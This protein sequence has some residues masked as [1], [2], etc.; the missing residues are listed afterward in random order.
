MIKNIFVII[1]ALLS[2]IGM[3]LTLDK[4]LDFLKSLN[5]ND[6]STVLIFIAFVF[7]IYKAFK[8]KDKRLNIIATIL[9]LIFALFE[10]V[11]NTIVNNGNLEGIFYDNFS[12]T[13]NIFKIIYY[14]TI[15]YSIIKIL[16][17]FFQKQENKN[18]KE[19]KIFTNNKKS[20]LVVLLILMICWLPYFLKYFPGMI[21]F[22][23][24]EQIK[25]AVGEKPLWDGNPISTTLFI[26]AIINIT[27]PIF[28]SLTISVGICT[29]LK[30]IFMA[31]ILSYSI[32]YLA[33]KGVNYKIRL[34]VLAFFAIN[35]MIGLYSVSLEK[36][37]LFAIILAFDFILLF[38][39][40]TNTDDFIKSKLKIIIAFIFVLLTA[41]VRHNGIYIYILVIPFLYIALRKKYIKLSI[42]VASSIISI[43]LI[44][45][46][47][48][49]G[50]NVIKSSSTEMFS[51]P[52]QAIARLAKY[53]DINLTEKEKNEIDLY[54]KYD[55]LAEAYNPTLADPE[56][57]NFRAEYIEKHKMQF[58]VLNIKLFV[59]YPSYYIEAILCNTS[60]YWFPESQ[61]AAFDKGVISNEL[62]IK[63]KTIAKNNIT[64]TLEQAT[65]NRQIPVIGMLFSTGFTLWVLMVII[66][67]IIYEKKYKLLV[68]FLPSIFNY[69]IILLGP[70][71][72]EF[73]YIIPMY[74]PLSIMYC[75]TINEIKK[76]KDSDKNE[77]SSINTMLQ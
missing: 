25:E 73:R 4:N 76:E 26:K 61:K 63:T 59:H 38:E 10:V 32:Y 56:K 37:S 35:P 15:V 53:N 22:D 60:G 12:I 13:K 68:A 9:G 43:Y 16:Y 66:F 77:N 39:F 11:G 71:N 3:N 52:L 70:S 64:D 47:L 24:L 33:K 8:Y 36:D 46:I 42:F 75:I 55:K 57:G 62:G 19:Y 44:N 34:L 58:I 1:L 40:V 31:L 41:L 51:A 27:M 54:V 14:T 50:F 74:L 28:N 5:G 20:I 21:G 2:T 29:F 72:T 18:I 6:I 69:I 48:I 49:Y 45:T 23:A 30:M 67:Y 17:E 65:E 7:L